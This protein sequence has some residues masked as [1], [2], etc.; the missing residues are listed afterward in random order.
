MS[1]RKHLLAWSAVA[2]VITGGVI[3]GVTRLR[4]DGGR[5]SRPAAKT[6]ALQT[7]AVTRADVS[8]SQ[9]QQG[10]IGF[11]RTWTVKAAGGG[12]V[13]WL[14][15]VGAKLTR[16]NQIYRV[17][18]KPVTL[19]YG[20][21]PLFRSIDHAGMVGRDIRVVADNLQA[22][23]YAIGRQPGP[24]SRVT[25]PAPTGGASAPPVVVHSGDSVLTTDLIQAI[26]R[27]QRDR[28]L[29]ENGHLTRTDVVI[30]PGP[31]RVAS[32]S[33]QTG[34]AG[35]DLM[36]VSGLDKVISVPVDA[37]AAGAIRLGEQVTVVLPAGDRK[38]AKVTAIGAQIAKAGT[39]QDD[40]PDSTPKLI[41]T[42][43]ALHTADLDKIDSADVEVDFAAETHRGVLTVPVGALLALSEG[44]YG[45]QVSGGPVVTVK[46]GL[47]SKGVAE[48]SGDGL[49]EGTRV[50]TTS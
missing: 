21:L 14:P 39:T 24:G 22:L 36:T 31:I 50:V 42:L 33:A 9:P 2:L 15:T 18:D 11:G 17:D 38:P 46:T 41:V 49:T 45:V 12:V 40:G 6:A 7:A 8:S 1:A 34:D 37:S 3:A 5:G 16:G 13:T 47:I 27:W 20:S 48:V 44:G 30:E 19:F 32:V 28:Q 35:G 29:P 26:K 4:A 43:T 25:V 10:N 23:G